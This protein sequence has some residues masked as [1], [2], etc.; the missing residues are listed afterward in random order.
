MKRIT[1]PVTP[2]G[3]DPADYDEDTLKTLNQE[4]D[5]TS[6]GITVAEAEAYLR[7]Y[8]DLKARVALR[9][10]DTITCHKT[11]AYRDRCLAVLARGS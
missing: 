7:L 8:D 6:S 3:N 1:L 4:I 5:A 10:K 11:N 2:E 9:G